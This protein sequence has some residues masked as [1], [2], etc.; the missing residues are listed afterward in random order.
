MGG[1]VKGKSATKDKTAQVNTSQKRTVS[2]SEFV[3]DAFQ[4]SSQDLEEVQ[5]GIRKLG[6]DTLAAQVGQNDGKSGV[7]NNK[8]Y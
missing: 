5:A 4:T 7:R 1:I 2:E 6:I 3:S 8:F